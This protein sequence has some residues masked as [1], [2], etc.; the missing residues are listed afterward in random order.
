MEK[1]DPIAAALELTPL[2][3]IKDIEILPP[4]GASEAEMEHSLENDFK[5]ARDN[6]HTVVTLGT[7]ALEKIV[8]VADN[9]QFHLD[10]QAVSR[11]IDSVTNANEKLLDLNQKMKD[12]RG[13][14]EQAPGQVQNNLFV[15]SLKDIQKLLDEK[16]E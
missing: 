15:G 11:L 10:Y 1:E 8:D 4:N 14:K 12:I 16:E 6:L 5:T 7:E 13:V 9:S 3:E 2:S